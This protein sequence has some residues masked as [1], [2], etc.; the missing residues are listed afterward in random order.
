[1]IGGVVTRT[2]RNCLGALVG[3]GKSWAC[4]RAGAIKEQNRS[5]KR[6]RVEHIS[7]PYG[8]LFGDK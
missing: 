7:T 2:A 5:V 1:M 4:V 6:E 3:A 8:F